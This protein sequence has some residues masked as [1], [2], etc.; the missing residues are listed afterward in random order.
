MEWEHF[1]T[2]PEETDN[3]QITLPSPLCTKAS[4]GLA[5]PRISSPI[6]HVV[7]YTQPEAATATAD[8]DMV[9][10]HLLL[11]SQCLYQLNQEALP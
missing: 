5:R 11:W 9:Q 4:R 6:M 7:T 10:C 1:K 2:I 3:G 8:N